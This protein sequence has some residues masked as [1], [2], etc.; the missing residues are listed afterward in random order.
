MIH[1][2]VKDTSAFGRREFRVRTSVDG[3]A[4]LDHWIC[5]ERTRAET[6]GRCFASGV[7][8]AGAD[9]RLT[10]LGSECR[11]PRSYSLP[12]GEPVTAA[13]QAAV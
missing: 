12:Y 6:L 8:F 1:V 9:L 13:N 5:H 3:S 11:V 2:D 7:A 10:I 4:W